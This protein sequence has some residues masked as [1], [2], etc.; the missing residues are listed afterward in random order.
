MFGKLRVGNPGGRRLLW[1]DWPRPWVLWFQLPVRWNDENRD[2]K[3]P[4]PRNSFRIGDLSHDVTGDALGTACEVSL[5]DFYW[6]HECLVTLLCGCKHTKLGCKYF[7][8]ARW[9]SSWLVRKP[10]CRW[11][12]TWM[13]GLR[14]E[15][16]LVCINF[17]LPVWIMLWLQTWL[18]HNAASS[19]QPK[20]Y[21]GF[22]MGL[23][24]QTC[25]FGCGCKLH[26]CGCKLHGCGCKLDAN[27]LYEQTISGKQ[28][29]EG[30]K[31]FHP[32]CPSS[33]TKF[34]H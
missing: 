34:F 23:W 14:H 11:V 31:S 20:V 28:F 4:Y 32:T 1:W 33:I 16:R 5:Y 22:N 25:S 8:F 17:S 27:H 12:Y 6:C 24:L 30:R 7:T 26:G 9:V 21:M 18:L 19:W 13:D 3:Y 10:L 2:Y 15:F 29:T